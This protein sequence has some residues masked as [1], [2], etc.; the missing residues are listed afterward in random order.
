[1]SAGVPVVASDTPINREVI[2]DGDTG[3]LIPLL[4]RSGRADRARHTDRVFTDRQLA[5][6][7]AN[8]ARQRILEEFRLENVVQRHGELYAEL[9]A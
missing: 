4:P 9:C 5:S 3:N 7:V 1:M 8:A 2:V 6:V